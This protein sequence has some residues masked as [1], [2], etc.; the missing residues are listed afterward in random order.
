MDVAK[1]SQGYLGVRKQNRQESSSKYYNSSNARSRSSS[2]STGCASGVSIFGLAVLDDGPM[3]ASFA[4]SGMSAFKI[5]SLVA[6]SSVFFGSCGL[7][8]GCDGRKKTR[9]S[10]SA[11]TKPTIA[12]NMRT[13]SV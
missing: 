11:V 9:A 3:I 8:I 2:S 4:M 10:M 13:R 7:S 6:G 5:A 1:L 12:Q